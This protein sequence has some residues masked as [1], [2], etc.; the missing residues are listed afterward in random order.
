MSAP[1]AEQQRVRRANRNL[2][3]VVGDEHGG[4]AGGIAGCRAE[5]SKQI[6][7][8]AEVQSGGGFVEQ[9]DCRIS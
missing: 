8:A 1:A 7:S 5:T 6:L 9:H 4:R 2:L 3:D